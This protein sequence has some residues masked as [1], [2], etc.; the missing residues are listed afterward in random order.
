MSKKFVNPADYIMPININGMEG[1]ALRLESSNRHNK[2]EILLIY[3]VADNLEK[4]WGLAVV[5]KSYANVTIIDLPGLGGMDSFFSIGLKPTLDNMADYIASYI[6]LKFKRKRLSM[7]AVGFGSVLVT[8]MMQRNKD[9]SAKINTLVFINGFAHKD[10]FTIKGF[11]RYVMKMYNYVCST[12][13]VS[14]ILKVTLFN[15][16][17]LKIRYP[18]NKVRVNR[19]GPAR[20]FVRRFLIDLAK[21]TDLRTKM[22]LKRELPNLDNCQ[23][24]IDATLWHIT[25]SNSELNIIS[26]LV[27]QHFQVIF[28]KYHQ[29]PTKIGGKMP[30]VLNN[31]KLAIKYLPGR[32]RRELKIRG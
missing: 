3:D 13:P 4:W 30:L 22:Y 10:D 6:K 26:K 25:T 16:L 9:I 7:I 11:D 21:A 19:G 32:I 2:K 24:R 29:L 31:D 23:V 17:A 20:T 27:D 12:K 18:L 28:N 5:L 14:D 15:T 1:R 8:R